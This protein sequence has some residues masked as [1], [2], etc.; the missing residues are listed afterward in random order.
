MTKVVSDYIVAEAECRDDLRRE[1]IEL[2]SLGWQ[3]YGDLIFHHH[4]AAGIKHEF[5]MYV[6]AMVRD[7]PK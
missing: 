3:P 5:D 2:M 7:E 4:P 6:Q 1:I